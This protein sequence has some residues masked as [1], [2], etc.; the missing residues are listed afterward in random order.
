M[1]ALTLE[2]ALIRYDRLQSTK[3]HY[4][5]HALG[6]Y[7]TRAADIMSDVER[8]ADLREAVI[9]GFTDRLRDYVLKQMGLAPLGERATGV[10]YQPIKAL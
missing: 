7:L 4:N 1:Q 6:I 8:G 2:Q 10:V 3:R 9:A 5:M